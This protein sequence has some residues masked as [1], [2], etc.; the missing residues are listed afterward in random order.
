MINKPYLLQKSRIFFLF[1][2]K[3]NLKGSVILN[4]TDLQN[5]FY[6]RYNVSRHHLCFSKAG[7]LCTFLGYENIKNTEFISCALS[8]CIHIAGRRLDSRIIRLENTKT[9]VCTVFRP[10]DA[11]DSMQLKDIFEKFCFSALPGAEL[12]YDSTIP[13][14]FSQHASL[15]TA[16]MNTLLKL[17]DTNSGDFKKTA[18]CAGNGN[19]SQYSALLAAKR[20]WCSYTNGTYTENLP[21]PLTGYKLLCVQTHAKSNAHHISAVKHAFE[22][23]RHIYPHISSTG[24]ITA[25][26]LYSVKKRLSRSEINYIQHLISEHE[27]I[28][29][30]KTALKAC[31]LY[32]FAEIVNASEYSA[33]QLWNC[34]RE[35]AFLSDA[36]NPLSGCL[37]SRQWKNGI[38]AIVAE[39]SI[40]YIIN[41]LR[42]EFCASYGYN[43]MFCISDTCSTE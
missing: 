5:D 22:T 12:L 29:T 30:A 41:I 23:I 26:I 33:Q 25:D 3:I 6:K 4:R 19:P 16:F 40:D 14:F 7:L 36:V 9:G 17:S 24:D 8:M 21:L 38:I 35:H 32:D 20:G 27:K 10:D 2:G 34:R 18:I 39:E 37:C 31:R 42:H 15:R 11:F 28:Q 1:L 43:P 13:P